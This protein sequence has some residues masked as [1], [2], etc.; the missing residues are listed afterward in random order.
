M[1]DQSSAAKRHKQSEK[2]RIRNRAVRSQVRTNIRKFLAAVESDT[3]D[4]AGEQ[5]HRVTRLLDGA[6][7]KGIYHRNTVARTKSRLHARLNRMA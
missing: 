4:A 2:H 7:G 6:A 1:R 3:K 5:L